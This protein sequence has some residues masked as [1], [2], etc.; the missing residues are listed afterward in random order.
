MQIVIQFSYFQFRW[1][2]T[3][4]INPKAFSRQTKGIK[5]AMNVKKVWEEDITGLGVKVA[6]IDDGVD[7]GHPDLVT[8]YDSSI[9]WDFVDND[10]DPYEISKENTHGTRM[11]GIISSQP[12]N[13]LCSAG[14]AFDVKS[15]MIRFLDDGG[16]NNAD[17]P[18]AQALA[19]RR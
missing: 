17:G 8:S 11:T 13:G 6:H 14:I 16:T 3:W 18:I 5:A 10:P 15:G 2:I 7:Y 12:N 4:H 9:S 19:F 1:N